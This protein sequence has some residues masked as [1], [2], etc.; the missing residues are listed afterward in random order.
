M[1]N[2]PGGRESDSKTQNEP[3]LAEAGKFDRQHFEPFRPREIDLLS[4][5]R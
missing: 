2:L 1:Y 3:I 4:V 5:P